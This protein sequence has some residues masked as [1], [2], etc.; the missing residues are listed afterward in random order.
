[1]AVR[2]DTYALSRPVPYL[3]E[4]AYA[5]ADGSTGQTI[6][7]PIR[8]TSDGS[9]VEVTESGS[10]VTVTDADGNTVVSAAAVSLSGSVPQYT[11]AANVPAATVG[12]GEGWTVIWSLVIDGEIY[13][14]RHTAVLCEYV[15]RNTVTAADLYGG[16]GIADLRYNVPQ[17]QSVDR[18]DG[19]GWAPQI[20]EAYFEFIRRMLADGRPIWRAREGTGYHTWLLAR[21]VVNAVDA[22]PA[23]EGSP[24]IAYRKQAWGR[25]Q[26]AEAGLRL[27]FD[28]DAP[29]V[30]R[31]GSGPIL[32][33]PA[34]RPQW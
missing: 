34:G 17:A 8:K 24:W 10:T 21:A 15:P 33:V 26:R 2:S 19:T 14:F 30:R 28:T 4:R 16:A 32:T 18:G 12:L 1:M 5:S 31:A 25:F 23:T 13:T 7:A 27:Q 9:L 29:D 22:I 20:D 3:L 6:E 11:F